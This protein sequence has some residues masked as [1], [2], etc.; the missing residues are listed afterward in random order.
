MKFIKDDIFFIDKRSSHFY[1]FIGIEN[2]VKSVFKVFIF[3]G[4]VIFEQNKAYNFV[5]K[6]LSFG[7]V[8]PSIG[9][10]KCRTVADKILE[11]IGFYKP[12]G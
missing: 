5:V 10:L 2:V 3:N 1:I 6:V 12:V 7:C 8:A 9:K 4:V 11:D